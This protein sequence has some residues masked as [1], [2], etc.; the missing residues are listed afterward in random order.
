MYSYIKVTQKQSS[1]VWLPDRLRWTDCFL[2]CLQVF[3]LQS[4]QHQ[5]TWEDNCYWLSR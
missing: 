1:E 2:G 4:L 3:Q 5:M